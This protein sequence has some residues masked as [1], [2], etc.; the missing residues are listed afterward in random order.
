[1]KLK[2]YKKITGKISLVTGLH[3]GG[4]SDVIEIGGMDNPVVKNPLTGDPYIPGSSLKGKMRSLLEWKTG[5][6]SKTGDP[7]SWNDHKDNEGRDCPICRIFG[8]SSSEADIGPTRLIVRDAF[9]SDESIENIKNQGKMLTEEKYEN[10]INRITAR[11][12]PRSIERVTAGISFEFEMVYRIFDIENVQKTDEELFNYV[13]HGLKFIQQDTLGGSGSRGCG[14]VE[15]MDLKD[16][17]GKTID[18][19]NIGEFEL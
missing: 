19:N 5:N 6:I 15:F 3:I 17:N 18:L 4:S 13:L 2:G 10:T 12:N 11:A 1:M 14:K 16:E 8:T 7:H 9:L